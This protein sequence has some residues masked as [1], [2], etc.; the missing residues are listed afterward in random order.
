MRSH[1]VTRRGLAA[2]DLKRLDR[3]KFETKACWTYSSKRNGPRSDLTSQCAFVNAAVI[4]VFL[5]NAAYRAN[6][7][8]DR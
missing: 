7:P 6:L 1:S 3:S 2:S 8:T 4:T 5:R